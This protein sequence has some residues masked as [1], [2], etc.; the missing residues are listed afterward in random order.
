M[1]RGARDQYGKCDFIIEDRK[2]EPRNS[3]KA[4][5]AYTYFYFQKTYGLFLKTN[6]ISHKN[7]KLFEVWAKYSLT[8]E[9]CAWAKKVEEIQGNRNEDLLMAC[10]RMSRQ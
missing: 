8:H 1:I 5:I 7:E 9:Q 4:L 10:E 6:Y 2:V 3:V